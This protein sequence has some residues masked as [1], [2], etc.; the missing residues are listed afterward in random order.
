[1]N[2]YFIILLFIT[3]HLLTISPVDSMADEKKADKI[4]QTIRLYEGVLKFP[5]APWVKKVKDLGNSKFYRDQQK[6]LFTLEQIPKDQEFESWKNLYGIYGFYLPE[7]DMKRFLNESLNALAMGC[8][9]QAKSKL[10]SAENG[11]IVMTYFC[12]DL[13][14]ELVVDGHNTESG[15]LYLSQVDKSFAK[16][17]MAWRAKKETMQTDKWPMNEDTVRQAI[18]R[19]QQVRYFSPK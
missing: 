7:Y 9:V 16:V 14:D 17:Y 8:K 11:A 4:A 3:I 10:V 6:H 1:M 13:A 5:P 19:L 15:F 12:S 18:Q 2:K